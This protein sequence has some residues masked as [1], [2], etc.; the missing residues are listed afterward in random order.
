MTIQDDYR[1]IVDFWRLYKRIDA[2]RRDLGDGF[3]SDALNMSSRFGEQRGRLAQRL[4]L[5]ML[6][7]MEERNADTNGVAQR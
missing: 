3:W 7:E 4:C 5:A 1:T 6:D 2:I